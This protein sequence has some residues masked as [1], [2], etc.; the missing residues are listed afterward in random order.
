MAE[1]Y[2]TVP[3]TFRVRMELERRVPAASGPKP[4]PAVAVKMA[5]VSDELRGTL[6]PKEYTLQAANAELDEFLKPYRALGWRE[7]AR[8]VRG[9]DQKPFA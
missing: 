6:H 2:T 3:Y 5:T 8:E 4:G 1:E 9:Y 7:M